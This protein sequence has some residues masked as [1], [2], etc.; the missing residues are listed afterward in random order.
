M[1]KIVSISVLIII[2][3]VVYSQ[4]IKGTIFDSETKTT[5]VL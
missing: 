3:S 2:G 4:V 5:H 1:K